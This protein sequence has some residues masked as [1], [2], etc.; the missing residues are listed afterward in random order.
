MNASNSSFLFLFVLQRSSVVMAAGPDRPIWY[1]GLT[2]L[3]EYLDGTLAGKQ[4]NFFHPQ[5]L[6]PPPH[7]IFENLLRILSYYLFYILL[8]VTTPST[9][10]VSALT[11]KCSP[12]WFRLN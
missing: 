3:P 12:G 8:Q 4:I 11:P 9:L 10:S 7:F 1:P 5:I 6:S 2:D